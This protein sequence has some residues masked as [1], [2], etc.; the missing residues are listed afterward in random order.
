M[1]TWRELTITSR[2]VDAEAMVGLLRVFSSAGREWAYSEGMS[3]DHAKSLDRPACII[4]WMG[5]DGSRPPIIALAAM[6]ED[7]PML[8]LDAIAVSTMDEYNLIAARFA[9]DIR[10][11]ARH[12]GADICVK[13]GRTEIGLEQLVSNRKARGLFQRYLDHCH[14]DRRPW[15]HRS[16]IELLARFTCALHTYSRKPVD[17]CE[18]ERYLQ[19]DCSWSEADSGR[20]IERIEMGLQVL[21]LSNPH[22]SDRLSGRFEFRH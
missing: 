4:E 15:G 11:W 5:S 18:L 17:L 8:S 7:C 6:D 9:K 13:L 2:S 3:L 19:E 21:R 14:L 12:T 1:K 22:M 10:R 20:C 16:N